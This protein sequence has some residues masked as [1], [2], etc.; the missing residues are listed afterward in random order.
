MTMS[1]VFQLTQYYFVLGDFLH[2]VGIVIITELI[3]DVGGFFLFNATAEQDFFSQ[4][5]TG[6]KC[7]RYRGA[8]AQSDQISAMAT[9][10]ARA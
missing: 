7:F 8:G 6:F 4:P 1:S 5:Q 9:I 3:N 10:R 2:H